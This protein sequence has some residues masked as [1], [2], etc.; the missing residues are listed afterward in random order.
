M[1]TVSSGPAGGLRG[2]AQVLSQAA[3]ELGR[4]FQG[5]EIER[6]AFVDASNATKMIIRNLNYGL[7]EDGTLDLGIRCA[8]ATI[9][10]P[11][12]EA[13]LQGCVVIT[14]GNG[15]KLMSNCVRWNLKTNQFTIPEMYILDREGTPVRGRGF[16]C[17]C[18]LEPLRANQIREAG[19]VPVYRF[20][21]TANASHFYTISRREVHKLT[22]QHADLWKYEGI[23]GYAY[24]PE[25]RPSATRPVHLLRR[26]DRNT[27]FLTISESERERIINR[28]PDVWTCDGIAFYAYPPDRHPSDARPVY[29]FWSDSVQSHF[30]TMSEGEKD[31]LMS[32]PPQI[33]TYEG[34]AWY[35]VTS[36]PDPQGQECAAGTGGT[37][38]S[39]PRAN[40]DQSLGTK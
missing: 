5:F 35:A 23:A 34:I 40:C 12:T 4:S 8:N 9:T 18:H 1:R 28:S 14:A 10:N 38:R 29:R 6:P 2:L 25:Q 17:D 7:F 15:H 16:R 13:V 20:C 26:V 19:P 36:G 37:V 39:V 32:Q 24:A 33:W 22:D 3:E 11:G 21:S 30:Y 31:K 27:Y